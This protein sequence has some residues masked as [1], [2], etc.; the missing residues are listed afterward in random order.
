MATRR[1][2]GNGWWATSW[3]MSSMRWVFWARITP[4]WRNISSSVRRGDRVGRTACPGGTTCPEVPAV[5]TI[6]GLTAASLRAIR[7]NLRGL[8]IDSRTIP[9]TWVP[10]SSSQNCIRSLPETSARCPADRNEE[11]PSR[12]FATEASSGTAIGADW[13]NSPRC[14]AAGSTSAREAF[15]G[16]SAAASKKP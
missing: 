12:R 7:E 5:T 2:R 11:T 16:G 14:P 9:T 1:P 10:G 6:T 13:Q 8:P 4:D 15:S 3:A